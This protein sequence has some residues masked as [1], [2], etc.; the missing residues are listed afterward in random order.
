MTRHHIPARTFINCDRCGQTCGKEPG[1]VSRAR[2]GAVLI[3][4]AALDYSGAA[5]ASASRKFDFCDRCLS[6]VIGAIDAVMKD[7]SHV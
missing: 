6:V 5:V 3:D 2:E 7:K 4:E 1:Q